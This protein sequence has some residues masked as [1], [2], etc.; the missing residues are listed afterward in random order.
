[1]FD[2]AFNNGV[3]RIQMDP[4]RNQTDSD[5]FT[6]TCSRGHSITT[7]GPS[8]DVLSPQRMLMMKD[9]SERQL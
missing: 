8:W 1:M 4:Q 3:G 7:K 2:R 9:A 6:S 5:V